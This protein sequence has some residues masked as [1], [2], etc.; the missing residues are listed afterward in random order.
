MKKLLSAAL[1]CLASALPALAQTPAV[2]VEPQIG[3]TQGYTNLNAA[4][5]AVIKDNTHETGTVYTITVNQNLTGFNN[6]VNPQAKSIILQGANPDIKIGL[7]PRVTNGVAETYLRT[8]VNLNTDGGAMVLKDLVIDGGN[9][10]TNTNPAIQ[11]LTGSLT[12]ENVKIQ[13]FSTT[14]ATNSIVKINQTAKQ[15]PVSTTLDN[16]SFSDCTLPENSQY[17]VYSNAKTEIS[18]KG[19]Y[20]YTIDL[21]NADAS[22]KDAGISE[23]SM[24]GI[25]CGNRTE[26]APIVTGCDD[27][28]KFDLKVDGKMLSPKNGN[29]YAVAKTNVLLINVVDGVKV[30]TGYAA[31]AGKSGAV[32]NAE[33]GATIVINNNVN[34]A[35]A[36]GFG[37]KTVEIRGV[38]PDVTITYT[39]DRVVANATTVDTYLTFR[40]LTITQG[41]D[42]GYSSYIANANKTASSVTFQNVT[43]KNCTTTADALICAN[44]GKWH[45]DNVTFDNCSVTTAETPATRAATA[46]KPLVSTNTAGCSI[47]GVNNNLSILVKDVVTKNVNIDASGLAEGQKNSPILLSF[48]ELPTATGEESDADLGYNNTNTFITGCSDAAYFKVQNFGYALKTNDTDNS[49]ALVLILTGIEEVAAEADGEAE[50]FDLRGVRVNAEALTPGLYI[51]RKGGKVSK[52]VIR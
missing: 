19:L 51:C 3:D 33:T 36:M 18:V 14:S 7:S 27:I 50:Y 13:N 8:F 20:N 15:T 11:Q 44:G 52:T 16:L 43:F 34:M 6:T 30:G 22:I 2:T 26:D 47:S 24:P 41:T 28:F 29:L 40:D 42:L 38:N 17:S 5:N 39:V 49:L 21:D 31:L 35:A 12:V 25:V 37:G 46:S 48:T 10:A 9:I 45:L 4:V 23:E 1:L 32:P